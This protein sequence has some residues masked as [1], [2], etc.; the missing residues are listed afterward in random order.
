MEEVESRFLHL[1]QPIRDL[2]KNWEVDVAAQLGEYLE[3]LEQICISFDN[4]KTTM[5]FVEAAL[6]I[7]GSASIYSKKVEHL[8]QMV[9][10][11]LDFICNKKRQKQVCSVGPDGKDADI[12][13]GTEQEEAFLSLDDIGDSSQASV[14]L[15][16]D[17]QPSRVELMPLTP[18][19]LVPAD[20]TEKR[21]NPLLSCKGELLA[22]RWDFRMNTCTLH[23]SGAFLLEP[24]SLSPACRL[25][26]STTGGPGDVR[27]QLGA[28]VQALGFSGETDPDDDIR[29]DISPED[30]AMEVPPAVSQRVDA[31]KSLPQPEGYAL[32]VPAPAQDPKTHLK[33][34]LD[35]WQ[36]LDPFADSEDKPFKKGRPFLV[37]PGLNDMV[38]YKRKKKGPRK[39]Q[40]FM[41]W[42][43][44]TYH[45]RS[46]GR[47]T[48]RKGPTFADLETFYWKE[49]KERL[50]V[51][52]K[53]QHPRVRW[54]QGALGSSW[55]D[56]P[57]E[58]LWPPENELEEAEDEL[59]LP[60]EER[61]LDCEG[62]NGDFLGHEM[63]PPERP[64]ELAKEDLAP[65][66]DVSYEELV[67]RNV[68]LFITNSQKYLQE[69]ELSQNLRCWEDRIRPLLQ[70]Q[71]E[72]AHFDIHS[73]GVVLAEKCQPLGQWHS[74][75]S[76]VRGMPPFK[77]SRYLLAALQLAND[78]V[79]EL[80]QEAGLEEAV[81]TLRLK[82]LT[83]HQE[84]L[85]RFQDL[86][87]PPACSTAPSTAHPSTIMPPPQE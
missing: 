15:R 48:K 61:G 9:C 53:L 23:A 5:N 79:V 85:Q 55:V 26:G 62:D 38:G 50:A 76:L 22:S 21:N 75:A 72:R 81:D 82:A 13:C 12:T 52:K 40:D 84:P 31:Q 27:E 86:Q 35:P 74:F 66:R 33:E 4:G 10:Q 71:E 11:V 67:R 77:V 6:V 7:Q 20:D 29:D 18:M 3:E 2:T 28:A 8:Y 43:S 46:N 65:A 64:E 49:Q 83:P 32:Q 80:A 30:D 39:L 14:D 41:R 78:S 70:E 73:Y 34:K 54:H 69:T 58:S 44:A 63:L 47:R 57:Q 17:Q 24:Y 59:E 60:E 25:E 45:D 87:L 19:C 42:F 37:P 68:E 36:S 56:V 1:L 16:R 51:W